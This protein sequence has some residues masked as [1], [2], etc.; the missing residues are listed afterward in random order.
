MEDYE[1][2]SVL[3]VGLQE[4]HQTP[5]D[6]PV[7]LTQA[8]CTRRAIEMLRVMRFDLLLV[9]LRSSSPPWNF[10]QAARRCWPGQ[11]WMLVGPDDVSDRDEITARSLGATSVLAGDLDWD[12]IAQIA[13]AIRERELAERQFI[14]TSATPRD[15]PRVQIDAS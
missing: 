10:V 11:K 6:L 12:A 4:A 1:R 14:S 13:G 5:A 9:A 15:G 2:P 7:E 3:G 8:D